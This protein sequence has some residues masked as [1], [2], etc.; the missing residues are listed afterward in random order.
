MQP[1]TQ[2]NSPKA[3]ANF[4]NFQ[5]PEIDQNNN[6]SNFQADLDDPYLDIN[7]LDSNMNNLE[8]RNPLTK[9]NRKAVNIN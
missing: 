9:N 3:H 2:T 1:L 5:S 4:S 6:P 8:S 7:N